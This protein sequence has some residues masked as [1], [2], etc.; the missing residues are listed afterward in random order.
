MPLFLYRCP[1]T[2]SHVQGFTAEDTSEDH[3]IYE[4]VICPICHQIHHVNPT[5]GAVLEE[6]VAERHP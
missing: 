6:N 4:P 3:H 5:T 1:R 2:G